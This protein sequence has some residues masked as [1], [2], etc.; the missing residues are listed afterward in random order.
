MSGSGGDVIKDFI[1][2]KKDD[3]WQ[4]LLT[5]QGILISGRKQYNK[6]EILKIIDKANKIVK[7]RYGY[8]IYTISGKQKIGIYIRFDNNTV[9]ANDSAASFVKRNWNE[10]AEENHEQISLF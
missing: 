5:N 6:N 3:K 10:E 9:K 2:Y 8:E 4:E 7:S 1:V